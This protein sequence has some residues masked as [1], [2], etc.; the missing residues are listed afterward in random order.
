MNRDEMMKRIRA[1]A[2]PANNGS[3]LTCINLLNRSGFSPLEQV[4]VGVKTGA[5]KS[6]NFWTASIS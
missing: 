1:D 4:R 2:F 6:R 3:V 5:W